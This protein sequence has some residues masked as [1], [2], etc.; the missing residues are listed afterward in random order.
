MGEEI[1][2]SLENQSEKSAMFEESGEVIITAEERKLHDEIVEEMLRHFD[3]MIGYEE[4]VSIEIMNSA[5]M[6][7]QTAILSKYPDKFQE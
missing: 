5:V 6:T 4:K 7:A 2:D 3:T 1:N